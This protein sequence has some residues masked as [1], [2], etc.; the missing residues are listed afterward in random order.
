MCGSIPN[1]G[2]STAIMLSL[3]Y[4][5][6]VV[7]AEPLDPSMEA[8]NCKTKIANNKFILVAV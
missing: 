5:L 6:W 2:V 8:V 7:R 3:I 1:F 4:L